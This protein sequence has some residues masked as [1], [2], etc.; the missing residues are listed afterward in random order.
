MANPKVG[1]SATLNGKKVVWSGQNYGWQ[2]PASHTKLKDQ[3]KF[4]TGAQALDR[5]GNAIPKPV[6]GAA[7]EIKNRL[8]NGY[9]QPANKGPNAT[10]RLLQKVSDKANIDRRIV[11]GAA[12]VAQAAISAKALKGGAAKAQPQPRSVG[13]AAK[14]DVRG[15]GVSASQA[16]RALPTTSKPS[17]AITGAA[18][19]KVKGS[20]TRQRNLGPQTKAALRNQKVAAANKATVT[21]KGIP[22]RPGGIVHKEGKPVTK[23]TQEFRTLQSTVA[24]NLKAQPQPTRRTVTNRP[25]AQTL[26]GSPT[27]AAPGRTLKPQTKAAKTTHAKAES[28]INQ[29][30]NQDL[31]SYKAAKASQAAKTAPGRTQRVLRTDK[32]VRAHQAELARRRAESV[33]QQTADVKP[34]TSTG[35]RP[36]TGPKAKRSLFPNRP[37]KTAKSS[38]PRP[39]SKAD[40]RRQRTQQILEPGTNPTRTRLSAGTRSN[41]TVKPPRSRTTSLRKDQKVRLAKS[42]LKDGGPGYAESQLPKSSKATANQARGAVKP[43]FAGTSGPSVNRGGGVTTSYGNSPKPKPNT[44]LTGEVRGEARRQNNLA[45]SRFKDKAAKAVEQKYG[46]DMDDMTAAER[47]AFKR[48]MN[49]RINKAAD[50][51]GK[52][53]ER[54]STAAQ[55]VDRSP[56]NRRRSSQDPNLLDK[57]GRAYSNS[58]AQKAAEGMGKTVSKLRAQGKLP[59]KAGK[60]PPKP[61]STRQSVVANFK[62]RTGNKP[63]APGGKPTAPG[64]TPSTG[65]N[66]PPV[67][68]RWRFP[69]T[70]KDKPR[71]PPEKRVTARTT[72]DGKKTT[73]KPLGQPG[74]KNIQRAPDQVARDK[75]AA[76]VRKEVKKGLKGRKPAPPKQTPQRASNLERMRRST[77]AARDER[78]NGVTSKSAGKVSK[79]AG[80]GEVRLDGSTV[81]GRYAFGTGS[82]TPDG[83][84][85]PVGTH[86][87]TVSR[88]VT[89]R[90]ATNKDRQGRSVAATRRGQATVDAVKARTNAKRLTKA[91]NQKGVINKST[92]K[93]KQQHNQKRRR[94]MSTASKARSLIQRLKLR[95]GS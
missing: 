55:T 93:T 44:H 41:S 37:A 50:R 70:T 73:L 38:S 60:N 7:N 67:T 87:G 10:D 35:S 80:P 66:M 33:S 46:F 76:A 6:R 83:R 56:T 49:S 14:A 72:P 34:S 78:R 65:A 71:K 90:A 53:A 75:R 54:R 29:K 16:R 95:I 69:D 12:T 36:N 2:S 45:Q 25:A 20:L 84:V 79:A 40:A 59:A 27:N 63:V 32:G 31:R 51:V 21:T 64:T 17:N 28:K 5:L 15:T 85:A 19:R 9:I 8:A 23:G 24:K 77:K 22:A 62:A 52:A 74:K 89:S 58:Y 61:A 18:G 26:K 94:A 13:A 48:Q 47:K 1:Q 92:A 81:G 39:S 3:G 91:A 86:D 68:R 82:G 88:Q 57:R 4:K 43:K 11:D 30:I 42:G